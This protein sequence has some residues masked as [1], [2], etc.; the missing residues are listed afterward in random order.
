MFQKSLFEIIF[1]FITHFMKL[2]QNVSHWK[3]TKAKTHCQDV[4]CGMPLTVE[5]KHRN[6]MNEEQLEHFIDYLVS[7][8]IVKDLPYGTKTMK[9]ST[10]QIVEVPNLIRS[11]AP[12]SLIEQYKQLCA[13][14]NIKHLGNKSK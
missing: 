1:Y 7:S 8:D 9:L 12:S 2:I 10:G 13:A 5:R 6:K 4:G 14:Q 11:L 3:F